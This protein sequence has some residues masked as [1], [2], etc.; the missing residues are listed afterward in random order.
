[1]ESKPIQAG[2]M[3]HTW[4]SP[5]NSFRHLFLKLDL[6]CEPDK[7]PGIV[8]VSDEHHQRACAAAVKNL[9]KELPFVS[10]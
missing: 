3:C 5:D 6:D 9:Q 7:H 8:I 4:R 1:M 10:M 2:G